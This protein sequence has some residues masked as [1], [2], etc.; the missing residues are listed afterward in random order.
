ME[1]FDMNSITRTAW[2]WLYHYQM[3]VKDGAVA[4]PRRNTYFDPSLNDFVESDKVFYY[5]KLADVED[6]DWAEYERLKNLYIEKYGGWEKIDLEN[7][8]YNGLKWY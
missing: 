1:N 8:E 3:K 2:Q 5:Y 6:I 7:T 4:E